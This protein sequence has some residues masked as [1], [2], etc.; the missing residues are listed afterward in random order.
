MLFGFFMAALFVR[1]RNGWMVAGVHAL[2]DLFYL[3]P[4]AILSG[5]LQS[6]Y[7]TGSVFDLAL[8]AGTVVL[9]VPLAVV[10]YRSLSSS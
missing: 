8:L 9:F 5:M 3:G 10:A 1:V 2:F 4:S 7:L 6:T